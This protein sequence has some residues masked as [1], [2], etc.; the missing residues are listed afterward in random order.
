MNQHSWFQSQVCESCGIGMH[1][2]CVRKYFRGQTEPRCPKCNEFWS[3]DTPGNN[4]RIFKKIQCNNTRKWAVMLSRT[5][6]IIYNSEYQLFLTSVV[7][8]RQ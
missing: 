4:Q 5:A 3:C 2:P 7:H 6:H 1:L 8:F